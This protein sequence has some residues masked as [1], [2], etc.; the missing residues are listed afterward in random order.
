MVVHSML[1]YSTI[2]GIG[3]YA[4]QDIKKGDIVWKFDPRFDL[5]ISKTEMI[6][7]NPAVLEFLKMYA[8]GQEESG[9]KT[10]ILCGDHARHMNHSEDPN[11]LETGFDEGINVAARDIKSGEEFT[12]NYH[13]FDTDVRVKLS[14]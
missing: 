8:Y 6:N 3:C 4:N 12:C 10:Y 5:V 7:L 14:I 2:H 1:K 11:V 13:A 9:K